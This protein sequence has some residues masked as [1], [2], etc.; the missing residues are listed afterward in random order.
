LSFPAC[1]Y[2][3][4]LRVARSLVIPTSV[5]GYRSLGLVLDH[6]RAVPSGNSSNVHI[7]YF[8]YST[9]QLFSSSI[10]PWHRP[11]YWLVGIF[12][13]PDHWPHFLRM[14]VWPRAW[15]W[16]RWFCV[17][18]H[19]HRVNSWM[20]CRHVCLRRLRAW[21][22]P[23]GW[24]AWRRGLNLDESLYPVNT[25]PC[26]TCALAFFILCFYLDYTSGRRRLLEIF[27]YLHIW[28]CTLNFYFFR[29]FSHFVKR[30][31]A[32]CASLLGGD[33]VCKMC[34]YVSLFIMYENRKKFS[35]QGEGKSSFW[36]IGFSFSRRHSL[37]PDVP[38]PFRLTIILIFLSSRH[39]AISLCGPVWLKYRERILRSCTTV[40][41]DYTDIRLYFL[42]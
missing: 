37:S 31:P 6:H 41:T 7:T 40:Y 17:V 30:D 3:R 32:I 28:R 20:H 12:R 27:A 18:A 15:H 1:P 33:A 26:M 42:Y 4:S 23:P 5:S 2:V 22:R 38:F 9:K 10:R 39:Y 14:V 34:T 35:W 13:F 29:F 16:R 19:C 25:W 21:D 24:G 8:H 11:W 36:K